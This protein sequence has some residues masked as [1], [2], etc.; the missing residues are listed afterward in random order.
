VRRF[1]QRKPSGGEML[2]EFTEPTYIT[3]FKILGGSNHSIEQ[4]KVLEMK[5]IVEV[6]ETVLSHPLSAPNFAAYVLKNV[7]KD[8]KRYVLVEEAKP[9][10]RAIV[11]LPL[12]LTRKRES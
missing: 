11:S 5:L 8:D 4:I 2:I 3:G 6:V 10:P 7:L 1:A 9:D 12:P